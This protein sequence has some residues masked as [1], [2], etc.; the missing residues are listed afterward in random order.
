VNAAVKNHVLG[1]VS[2]RVDVRAGVLWHHNEAGCARPGLGG[3]ARVVAAQRIVEAGRVRWMRGRA[4]ESRLFE[5]EDAG[6]SERL[7]E[8]GH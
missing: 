2:Q 5:I 4:R 8:A 3:A 7:D 1:L 6:G